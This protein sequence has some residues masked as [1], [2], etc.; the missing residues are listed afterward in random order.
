M[1]KAIPIISAFHDLTAGDLADEHG[2][3][4]GQIA[5]LD[6]QARHYRQSDPARRF[7]V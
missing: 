7:R 5:D 1:P 6:P 2:H 4:S 3:L